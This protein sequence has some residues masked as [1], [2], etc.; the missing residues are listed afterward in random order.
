MLPLK[1]AQARWIILR[2]KIGHKSLAGLLRIAIHASPQQQHLFN[3]FLE[4]TMKTFLTAA[5][6]DYTQ[7][8]AATDQAV[9]A[10]TVVIPLGEIRAEMGCR[11]RQTAEIRSMRSSPG[12]PA[13]A[14]S[15]FCSPSERARKTLTP[16]VQRVTPAP[17]GQPSAKEQM[18]ETPSLQLPPPPLSWVKSQKKISTV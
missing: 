9:G 7:I 10:A 5:L 2:T 11:F 14:R 6:M 4:M 13:L 8:V 1:L 15:A 17:P 18:G 12:T 16:L 3:P